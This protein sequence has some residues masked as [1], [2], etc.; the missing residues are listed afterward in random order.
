MAREHSPRPGSRGRLSI[1]PTAGDGIIP[2]TL[3]FI[4]SQLPAW[5]DDPKR[6]SDSSEKRLNYSLC[7]FLDLRSRT[8]HPMVRFVH[9]TLQAG[10]HSADI[11][12]HGADEETLV[13]AVPYSMYEP[14]LVLEAKRLPAPTKDRER[15]Y[16]TGPTG[17]AAKPTGGIQRFKLSLHG[18][19]VETAAVV[20]Y[21]QEQSPEHW[22]RT[23]NGWIAALDGSTPN[24]CTWT[25]SETLQEL[26]SDPLQ[27]TAESVSTHTRMGQC[28]SGS[29][30]L[31]HLWVS[32]VMPSPG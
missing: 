19:G 9:E 1:R 17:D 21:V 13:D 14:F 5:R 16:V 32:M 28:A 2:R 15:E 7:N 29:I 12:I 27:G 11:G 10:S 4:R 8:L 24:G 20:G 6:P 31:H 30:T 22:H 3:A 23:I 25:A 18:G 26:S